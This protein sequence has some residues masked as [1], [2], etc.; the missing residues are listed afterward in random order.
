VT[1][2]TFCIDIIRRKEVRTF[3]LTAE[4]ARAQ[5][6]WYLVD[7][8]GKVLGRLAAKIA[9]I[10]RG[11]HKPIF[12]PHLDVGDFVVVINADKIRL[13]GA[14]WHKKLYFRHSGY[15]GGLKVETAQQ[16]F[17]RKPEELLRLAVAGMLPKNRL[18]RK[19]LKKLKIYRGPE[20]P[21]QAQKPEPLDLEE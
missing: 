5:R 7:A 8:R 4:E 1:S 19:L 9:T 12:S 10:L 6:K 20:H 13:T 18:G 3:H 15:P 17:S 21:H 2:L 14:K 16:L 11:K